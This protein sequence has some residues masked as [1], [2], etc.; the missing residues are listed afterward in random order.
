L[1]EA[2]LGN[3]SSAPSLGRYSVDVTRVPFGSNATHDPTVVSKALWTRWKSLDATNK[4][5]LMRMSI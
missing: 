3:G 4:H 5:K 2:R 1:V